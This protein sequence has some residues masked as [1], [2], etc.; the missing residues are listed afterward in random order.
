MD[1]TKVEI[2]FSNNEKI[3]L[4]Y[5]SIVFPIKLTEHK[6]E[7]FTSKS[8]PL[9]LNEWHHPHDGF[10]PELTRVFAENEFFTVEDENTYRTKVYKSSAIV[11]LRQFED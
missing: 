1:T 10:I 5:G 7:K 3:T 9:I 6:G 11:S 4:D 2:T 8:T